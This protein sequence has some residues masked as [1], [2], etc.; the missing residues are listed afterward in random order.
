MNNKFTTIL[1]IVIIVSLYYNFKL[2]RSTESLSGAPTSSN[3]DVSFEQKQKCAVYKK[4]IESKFERNNNADTTVTFNYFDRI[5]YS[6]TRNSCLYVYNNMFGLK[7]VDHF[8]TSYLVDALSG[9][10]LVNTIVMS[11][12]QLDREAQSRFN[13]LVKTYEVK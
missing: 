4:D 6:P 3:Q 9:E 8:E 10:V 5:F 11:S 1:I 13:E 2:S 12:G 7:A